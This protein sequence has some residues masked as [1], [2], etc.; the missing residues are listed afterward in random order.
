[1]DRILKDG[2]LIVIKH[3]TPLQK[4]IGAACRGPYLF[5][6]PSSQKSGGPSGPPQKIIE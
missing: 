6:K 2:R 1:M 5:D 3:K 4:Q